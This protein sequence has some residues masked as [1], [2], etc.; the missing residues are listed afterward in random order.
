[1]TPAE[2]QALLG[3]LTKDMER[4]VLGAYNEAL[5]LMRGGMAPRDAIAQV[6][7]KFQGEAGQ[8]M[9]SALSAV[10]QRSVGAAE[11]LD[12]RVGDVSL[13]RRL[14]AESE[15]VSG[16]VQGIVQRH[17]R[18]AQDARAL[19]LQLF[20]GY[21]FREPGA[22]PIQV[23]SSNAQLPKYM[24]ELLSDDKVQRQMARGFARMQIDNLRTGALRAAYSELLDT[25]EDIEKG[26]LGYEALDKRLRVAFFERLRFF[27][28]R[29][30]RTETHRAYSEREARI[31]MDDAEIEYV[32][33]RRSRTSTQPCIC[34]LV[35]KRDRYG[36]GPGVY[37]K[38]RAPNPPLHP[39]C[40][41]IQSPRLDLSGRQAEP[42]DPDADR[43]FLDRLSEPVAARV[44][45]SRAK[46][47]RVQ[48]GEQAI[49]V[50]NEGVNPTYRVKSLGEAANAY[51]GPT[52]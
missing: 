44:I 25:L 43:Y 13:S 52:P 26:D 19:A 45:G 10:L 41:C 20:E 28:T 12:I 35:T 6:M 14:Y 42:E 11:A 47:A 21:D 9:A 4:E 5:R 22:E 29:I 24:R 3:Q 51:T 48:N 8:L 27:A 37:P 17:V 2:E 33:I 36:L 18:G 31:L 32:Q 23:T 49:S 39:Y 1:M 50:Y 16:I 7:D 38:A 40:K 15:A 30:A 46:L 34:D